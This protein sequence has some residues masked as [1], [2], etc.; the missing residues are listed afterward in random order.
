MNLSDLK[1]KLS[2]ATSDMEIINLVPKL[3]EIIEVQRDA[4]EFYGDK[5]NW[6]E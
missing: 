5:N 4:L 2:V 1:E 6:Q 3:L